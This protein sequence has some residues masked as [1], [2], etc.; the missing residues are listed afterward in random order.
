[1]SAPIVTL[2]AAVGRNGAIGARNAI[3]W[4]LSSDMKRFKALTLG[5]PLIMGRKT[6]ESIGKPLPGRETL[7][8]TRDATYAPNGI[9]VVHDIDAALRLG[10]SRARALGVGEIVV[11]GGGEVYAQTI[12]LAQRLHITEVDL[13]PDADAHFPS[14]DRGVWR[15]VAREL[16]QRGPRDEADFVFV[17]YERAVAC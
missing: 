15:E 16:G 9:A 5:R 4:R 13:A 17:D 11:A 14:I 8:I 7:V 2:I 6:F 10:E 12:G 3:P 1:M